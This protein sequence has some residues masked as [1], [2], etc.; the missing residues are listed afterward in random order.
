[1]LLDQV[2]VRPKHRVARGKIIRKHEFFRH[3]R[4]IMSLQ[5]KR[6]CFF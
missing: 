6:K 2:I 5:A 3:A 1:L 4:N